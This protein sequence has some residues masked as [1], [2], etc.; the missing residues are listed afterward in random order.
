MSALL[1]CADALT[2]K[3]LRGAKRESAEL[4]DAKR[5]RTYGHAMCPDHPSRRWA[6]CRSFNRLRAT[7]CVLHAL[8]VHFSSA[9]AGACEHA[10]PGACSKADFKQPDP[11]LHIIQPRDGEVVRRHEAGLNIAFQVCAWC[12]LDLPDR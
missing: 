10:E 7:I 2:G 1:S 5:P 8:L 9:D 11:E 3:A 6:S 4:E 12:R